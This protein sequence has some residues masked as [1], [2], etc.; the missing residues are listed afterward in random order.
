MVDD[1]ALDVGAAIALVGAAVPAT[2]DADI[3]LVVLAHMSAAG[4]A[5]LQ[6]AVRMRSMR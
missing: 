4:D 3:A 1:G 5:A 2:L 6:S